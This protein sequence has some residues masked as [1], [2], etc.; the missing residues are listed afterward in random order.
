[1]KTLSAS[2]RLAR[3]SVKNARANPAAVRRGNAALQEIYE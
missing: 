3:M 1:M 2:E